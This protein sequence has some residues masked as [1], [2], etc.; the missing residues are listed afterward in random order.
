MVTFVKAEASSPT[1]DLLLPGNMEAVTEAPVLARA[2]GYLRK[3]YADIGDHVKKGQ[4][5]AE[6]DSP[7]LDQQVAQARAQLMQAEAAEKQAGANLEQGKAN[8]ALAHVTAVRWANLLTKGAVS[9]QEND[10]YQ[11]QYQAQVANVNSLGQA[12]QAAHQNTSSVRSNLDRLIELQSYEHVRAPF[13]GV[14]TLRNVD[15]GALITTGT[16]L[17]FRV[18]QI[19]RLRTYVYAPQSDAPSVQ[20][21]QHAK[22][23]VNEY[24]NRDFDGIITRT[25]S[26][27]DPQSRTLLTEVQVS[28]YDGTLFPG[29]YALVKMNSARADR[30]ILVPGAALI[31]RAEGTFIATLKDAGDN[32][33]KNLDTVLP[34]NQEGTKEGNKAAPDK[35]KSES[36]SAKMEKDKQQRLQEEKLPEFVVRLVP[37]GIGRDYGTEIEIVT[38]L[39]GGERV[40]Q[41]PNDNVQDKAH[42]RGSLANQGKGVPQP[43]SNT[44]HFAT[45]PEGDK[46]PKSPDKEMKN[47]G[48]GY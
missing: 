31:V 13:D 27:L 18:A 7:E 38:G 48:P 9:R 19:D 10:Q 12:L 20:V 24:P 22:V 33:N 46:P 36:P 21:G 32:K 45:Q 11:A 16:T 43:S 28:N 15:V 17:L 29:M 26:S 14:I 30:P 35:K 25:S 42:V 1:A 5:L 6:V 37:V 4:L 3:R 44:E 8:E 47:R 2:D 39:K 41:A 40:V 34:E 23:H